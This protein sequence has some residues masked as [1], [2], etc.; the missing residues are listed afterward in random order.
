MCLLAHR[1]KTHPKYAKAVNVELGR[2]E[3]R[4]IDQIRSQEILPPEILR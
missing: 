4:L 2:I 3:A 1:R